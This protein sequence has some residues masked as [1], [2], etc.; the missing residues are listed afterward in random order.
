MF[1]ACLFAFWLRIKALPINTG[2]LQCVYG[3]CMTFIHST[4]FYFKSLG[5]LGL[6]HSRVFTELLKGPLELQIMESPV[7]G[8]WSQVRDGSGG[9]NI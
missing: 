7:G 1:F 8:P 6:E 3:R 9:H 2:M 4:S 5:D